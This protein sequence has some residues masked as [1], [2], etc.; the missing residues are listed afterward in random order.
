MASCSWGWHIIFDRPRT[1]KNVKLNFEELTVALLSPSSCFLISISNLGRRAKKKVWK[2]RN[3]MIV[4]RSSR[5]W[6]VFW[7]IQMIKTYDE[8]VGLHLKNCLLIFKSRFIG[9]TGL[10]KLRLSLTRY[11]EWNS[12]H[13]QSRLWIWPPSKEHLGIRFRVLYGI[14]PVKIDL[15]VLQWTFDQAFSHF[16]FL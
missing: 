12:H 5:A 4:D 10:T 7:S 14:E 13:L 2:K 8:E 15:W 11:I 9:K 6:F 16:Y 3:E 1:R